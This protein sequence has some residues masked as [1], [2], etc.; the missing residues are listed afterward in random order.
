[1]FITTVCLIL[2]I[3]LRWP[4]TK[5][6]YNKLVSWPYIELDVPYI[7]AVSCR[8]TVHNNP[9]LKQNFYT[10]RTLPGF[11]K[12][13]LRVF[14]NG[15]FRIL[16]GHAQWPVAIVVVF[17]FIQ[18]GGNGKYLLRFQSGTSLFKSVFV[19]VHWRGRAG[20]GWVAIQN[21]CTRVWQTQRV[22]K[23]AWT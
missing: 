10:V 19:F 23:T 5:S 1:M 22:T 2:L 20:R 16:W 18:R 12:H 13:R 7:S 15:A 4:K 21:R 17:R 3:K 11:C 14:E 6:L 9:S 8:S